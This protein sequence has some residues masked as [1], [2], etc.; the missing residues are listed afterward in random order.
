MSSN[1][2]YRLKHLNSDFR[3]SEISKMPSLCDE[4]AA[5]F[6]IAELRKDNI[7]PFDAVQIIA[8]ALGI[9]PDD[10]SYSGMKDRSG[11]TSQLIALRGKYDQ[12]ALDSVTASS[13]KAITLSGKGYSTEPMR[14][15]K[16]HGNN[17]SIVLRD[18][19]TEHYDALREI[20]N[21]TIESP[22]VNYYDNQRF[23]LRGILN[24]HLIK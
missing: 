14:I 19:D 22:T 8:D 4:E 11:V 17:F 16:L 13:G 2:P 1:Q 6:T 21:R 18:I 7:N 15:G 5:K 9:H 24:T 10:I 12:G 3:V 23:G 20:N